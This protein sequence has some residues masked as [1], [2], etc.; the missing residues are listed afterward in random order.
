MSWIETIV[1]A[2]VQGLTEFLPVSS[3]GHMVLF[4][5]LLGV[6]TPGVLLEVALHLGTLVAVLA[7]FRSE[8]AAVVAGFCGGLR[9]ILRGGGGRKIWQEQPH[10]RMGW[11]III[12]TIPAAA[13]GLYAKS[14]IEGLFSN[15]I[16][17]MAMLFLTGEILW[18]T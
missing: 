14:A 3:S 6:E 17:A 9:D 13:L 1:I 8:I 4:K 7:V 5:T 2:I 16:L 10:Y 11:Y 12:G 15:G 18:L